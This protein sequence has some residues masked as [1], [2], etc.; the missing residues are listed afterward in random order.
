ME[1]GFSDERP[2]RGS[3]PAH[4]HKCPLTTHAR[5][6]TCTRSR[7]H[8]F[9]RLSTTVLPRLFL[10]LCFLSSPPHARARVNA[11]RACV[12]PQMNPPPSLE[13]MNGKTNDERMNDEITTNQRRPWMEDKPQR[14]QPQQQQPQQ[15]PQQQ[16]QQ[17]GAAEL[18]RGQG[19]LFTPRVISLNSSVSTRSPPMNLT[20]FPRSSL[21]LSENVLSV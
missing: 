12:Y 17:M 18:P 20:Y 7:H 15:Q 3:A 4:S 8:R 10:K 5:T 16:Q 21:K 13:Q 6:R 19:R 14:Q 1:R 9:S 11:L 2:A